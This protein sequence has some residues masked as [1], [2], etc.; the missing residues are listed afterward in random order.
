MT[1]SATAR[2]DFN[3]NSHGD[4]C[5]IGDGH[6]AV[7]TALT[8]GEPNFCLTSIYVNGK[9]GV[10]I[11]HVSMDERDKRILLMPCFVAVAPGMKLRTI[12]GDEFEMK[13]E[14]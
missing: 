10:A 4:L 5:F 8:S 3:G 12:E 2:R 6:K 14:P 1:R 13:D 9:P 11:V 7:F